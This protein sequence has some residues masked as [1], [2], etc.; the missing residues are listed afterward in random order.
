MK[1]YPSEV[2]RII[3]TLPIGYYAD[4]QIPIEM[5]EKE[6]GKIKCTV[7]VQVGNMFIAWLCSFGKGIKAVSPPTVVTKVKEH[8]KNTMEQYD[9]GGQNG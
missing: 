9:E 1:I 4:K 8:L 2:K 5:S 7:E 3:D 6:D